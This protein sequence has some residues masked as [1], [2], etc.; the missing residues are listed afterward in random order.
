MYFSFKNY[1]LIVLLLMVGLVSACTPAAPETI[2]QEIPTTVAV[3][4]QPTVAA[5][6]DDAS[7]VDAVVDDAA[8]EAELETGASEDIQSAAP[9]PQGGPDLAAAAAT[10]NVSEDALRTALGD[11]PADL[12]AAAATLGVEVA[13]LQAALGPPP[14]DERPAAAEG[15]QAAAADAEVE[16]ATDTT[17]E[18]VAAAADVTTTDVTTTVSTG[19]CPA[20]YFMDVQPDPANS[21]YPDPR[22]SVTCTET[23]FTV[24]ANG[25][26]NF[27]F[28]AMTPNALNEIDFNLVMPINPT[29][30]ETPTSIVN[31]LQA[32]G[33]FINGLQF[34]GPNE[35]GIGG[36]GDP[37][38]D[39]LLDFCNGHTSPVEYHG[40]AAPTCLFDTWQTANLVVGY[41]LDG[42]P[43]LAPFVCADAA[44]S[45]LRELQSSW[46]RTSDVVAAWEAHEYV[47]GSGDLDECNGMVQADG[48]YAYYAT[49]TFPYLMGCIKGVV[50]E[51]TIRADNQGGPGGGGGDGQRPDFAAAAATLGITEDALRDALGGPPPDFDAA[52]ATLGIPAETLQAA[53]GGAPA[54]G[55][56][57][58]PAAPEDAQPA[59]AA[60]QPAQG[61][62]PQQGA[63]GQGEGA[64]PPGGGGGRGQG[65]GP[66]GG[67]PDFAGA[68]ATLGITEQAL[69]DALGGPPPN[70]EAAAATLGISVEVLQA[71]MGN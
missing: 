68:A 46:Q 49:S 44:C 51:G 22:L 7:T 18:T 38:L 2:V 17:T 37:Y 23:T 21:A 55:G 31:S 16:P 70:F 1:T 8:V 36:Y 39:E 60:Q 24:S 29:I 14:Q 45:S 33:V 71:A 52:A 20:A 62:P 19:I 59:D 64:G 34:N 32:L 35:A 30:A 54:T 5:V 69:R 28:V 61:Q 15:E 40:H 4:I 27:E 65:G 42:Y 25:I 47:A 67:P 9:P 12:D 41:A 48:S 58:P 11:P 10:L 53:M 6:A 43:V 50:P 3:E 66:Q 56:A 13:A 63:E 26:P 57:Q